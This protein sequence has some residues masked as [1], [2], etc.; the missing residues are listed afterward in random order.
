[1]PSMEKEYQT[2][3]EAEPGTPA[4]AAGNLHSV[5]ARPQT[6]DRNL[7]QWPSQRE[8]SE[9]KG[10]TTRQTHSDCPVLLNWI[11]LYC[12]R[13]YGCKTFCFFWWWCVCIPAPYIPSHCTVSMKTLACW[14][15]CILNHHLWLLFSVNKDFAQCGL[16]HCGVSPRCGRN[17]AVLHRGKCGFQQ[18][19]QPDP[20]LEIRDC[21]FCFDFS[22]FLY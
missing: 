13:T 22:N 21:V 17:A 10:D 9:V 5:P 16:K 11:N 3:E 2:R 15:G 6:D 8:S 18:F 12:T 4:A 1:M 14:W 7:A 20:H 19:L